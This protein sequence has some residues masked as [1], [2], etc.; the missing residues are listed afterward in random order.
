MRAN[1]HE[2]AMHDLI[3]FFALIRGYIFLRSSN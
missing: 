2:S 3:R 1:E